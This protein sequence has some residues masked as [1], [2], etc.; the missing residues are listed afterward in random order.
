MRKYFFIAAA[1]ILLSV[2]GMWVYLVSMPKQDDKIAQV[3]K[4][5]A[6]ER[7]RAAAAPKESAAQLLSRVDGILAD[8]SGPAKK[9]V[10]AEQR[11]QMARDLNTA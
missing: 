6:T 4:E 8:F 3:F 7:Q 1:L 2:I 9:S 5:L 11:M 10:T